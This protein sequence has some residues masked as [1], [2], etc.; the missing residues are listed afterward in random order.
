M[1]AAIHRACPVG[2]SAQNP[3]MAAFEA[4]LLARDKAIEKRAAKEARRLKHFKDEMRR[5]RTNL[6]RISVASIIRERTGQERIVTWA[7][8]DTKG[9]NATKKLVKEI[10]DA[11]VLRKFGALSPEDCVSREQAEEDAAEGEEE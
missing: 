4:G 3:R 6:D 10:R 2:P 1:P 9:T 5:C 7:D 8:L 11:A